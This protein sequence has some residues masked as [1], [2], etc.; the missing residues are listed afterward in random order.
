MIKLEK[1]KK[2]H[3]T[4]VEIEWS[5]DAFI[6]QGHCVGGF[7]EVEVIHEVCWKL[8]GWDVV[9]NVSLWMVGMLC[10][11]QTETTSAFERWRHRDAVCGC[12]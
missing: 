3:R 4:S 6:A 10:M 12:G 7:A 2:V 8:F 9:E 11:V 5:R 1:N